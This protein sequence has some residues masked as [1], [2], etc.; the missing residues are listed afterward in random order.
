MADLSRKR[1]R[2]RLSARREPY[3][4]RLAEGAA[5][6]F[7]R[8]P[9]TWVARYRS[10]DGKHQYK[11][12]GEALE[13]DDAKRRAEAWLGQFAGSAVRTVKRSTV[14]AALEAYLADL[15]RHGRHDAAREAEWRFNAVVFDHELADAELESM[16]RDDFLEW[17]DRICTGRQ[18]RTVNRYVRAVVAALNCAV[19]LGHV[20]NPVAWRVRALADDVEDEGE[21]AVFLTADQRKALI[22]AADPACSVFMRGLELTGARPRELAAATVGDFDGKVLR[23]AHRK[24]RPLRLRVRHVVLSK[25]GVAFFERQTA[26]KL[27]TAPIFTEDGER[28]WR[29]HIWAREIRVAIGRVNEKA[30]GKARIP[31]GSSAYS[32]RHARISELLQLHGVDLLTVAHQTGTSIAMIERAYL[33]FIPQAFHERLSAV[34]E[35]H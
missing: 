31:T 29:R 19:E 35:S 5:L 16:T 34:E 25:E 15:R 32:F 24:G 28:P 22:A 4:Q 30:R 26:D 1:E 13:F 14:R 8:G 10:R 2:E 6:G 20:G 17:R 3:W 12:L 21:T 18:A 33:R 27:P 9:D 23:L 7:R 11:A